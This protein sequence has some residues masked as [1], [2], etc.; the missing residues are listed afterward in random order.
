MLKSQK[1]FTLIELVMVIVILGILAAVAIPKYIDLASNAKTAACSGAKGA[2][3]SAAA[4]SLASSQT[5]TTRAAVEANT[6]LDGFTLNTTGAA[7]GEINIVLASDATYSCVTAN[8][9][10]AG[11]TTD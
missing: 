8:L 4:I 3:M 1:G 11:L 5:P 6:V 7:A 9:K 2:V 10:A